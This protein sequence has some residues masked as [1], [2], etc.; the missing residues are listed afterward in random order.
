MCAPEPDTKINT[1]GRLKPL[2]YFCYH[3]GSPVCECV[4]SFVSTRS[5]QIFVF[6]TKCYVMII[7]GKLFAI[8]DGNNFESNVTTT[9]CNKC[10]LLLLDKFTSYSYSAECD[11]KHKYVE[12][13]TMCH[14]CTRVLSS[15]GAASQTLLRS[16]CTPKQL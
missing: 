3:V 7:F 6:Y 5:P 4:R 15:Q 1:I 13:R 11:S 16:W 10:R 8:S 9:T 14:A 2:V 12:C